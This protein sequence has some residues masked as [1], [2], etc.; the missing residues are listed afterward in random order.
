MMSAHIALPNL[1][2]ASGHKGGPTPA[3]LSK[4]I[5]TGLLRQ[6]LGFDGL[7]V[8]DA[9]DMHALD[10]GPGLAAEAMAALDAGA[11]L[12]LFNH[13][14]AK[15]EAAFPVV[16]QAARRGLLA[17]AGIQASAR[18]ILALKTWVGRAKQP[19][20]SVIGSRPHRALA[21]EVARRSVTLVRK[22]SGRLPL[23]LDRAARVA[24][25]VPRPEDLTPADTSS[26]L[27]PTLAA[28]IRRHHPRVE[29]IVMPMAPSA[30]EVRALRARLAD[31]DLAVIGTINATVQRGQADLVEA[32]VKQ[33]TP[34]IAVALRTPYDLKAY[35]AVKTYAC[36]YSILPPSMEA[37]ADAL[38]GK[39]AFEGRLPVSLPK[40][41]A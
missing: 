38:F 7:I 33:G 35:P 41:L 17:P 26:Y 11:D 12:V 27:I 24:V 6:R 39:A 16:A 13:D 31:C 8:T 29:E 34:T 19:P 1:N 37:L 21:L 22:E 28:A 40:N 25:L 3:T 36:T 15:V 20:L 10:Q 4:T 5:L 2:G 14:L 32:V 23:R 18:R 9:M 30:S